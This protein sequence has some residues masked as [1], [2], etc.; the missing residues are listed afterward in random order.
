[1]KL[2]KTKK[3]CGKNQAII[4]FDGYPPQGENIPDADAI[5]V[6]FSRD[7][8]ADEKIKVIVERARNPKNI[9]VVSDDNEIRFIVKS[10]GAKVL[11]AREFIAPQHSRAKRK[12]A[13][14]AG[15]T[16]SQMEDINKELRSL[17]L[18]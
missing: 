15:L 17:W 7:Q 9:V 10:L 4:V 1:M 13:P 2:I 8:S 5:E 3:L 11:G 18:K 6:V 14:E 16:Y 12:E